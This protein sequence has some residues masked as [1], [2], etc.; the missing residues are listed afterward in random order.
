MNNKM[1]L[2]TGSLATVISYG[3]NVKFESQKK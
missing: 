2:I 3:A 1:K